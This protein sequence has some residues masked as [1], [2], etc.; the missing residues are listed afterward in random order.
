M[1]EVFGSGS[2]LDLDV[3]LVLVYRIINSFVNSVLRSR[4]SIS[5]IW[6]S[7]LEYFSV[8]QIDLNLVS[9]YLDLVCSRFSYCEL[10]IF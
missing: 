8:D 5:C 4:F 9:L 7:S 3:D 10:I 6:R 1:L 2:G